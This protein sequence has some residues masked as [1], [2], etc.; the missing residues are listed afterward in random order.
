[1]ALQKKMA[2]QLD[3]QDFDLDIFKVSIDH[4]ILTIE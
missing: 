4:E 2:E 1:M 3:D